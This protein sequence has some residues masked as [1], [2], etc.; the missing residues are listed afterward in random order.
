MNWNEEKKVIIFDKL[1]SI[2]N[3]PGRKYTYAPSGGYDGFVWRNENWTY[4]Q[5][6]I[7]VT[8]LQDGQAPPDQK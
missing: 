2:T 8:I 6:L 1:V 7:P 5:D 4:V 3:D